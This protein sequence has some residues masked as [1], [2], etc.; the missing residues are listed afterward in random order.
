M[1]RPKIMRR[2]SSRDLRS[3]FSDV[4]AGQ[5]P[6]KRARV[7]APGLAYGRRESSQVE[8]SRRVDPGN[9]NRVT[10]AIKPLMVSARLFICDAGVWG[11]GLRFEQGKGE[12]VTRRGVARR[13]PCRG[14]SPGLDFMKSAQLKFY[15]GSVRQLSLSHASRS[16]PGARAS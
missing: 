5:A 12:A 16:Y 8:S 2:A 14:N 10:A 6:I 7:C 1:A 13:V 4:P 9:R 15:C 11:S 3:L